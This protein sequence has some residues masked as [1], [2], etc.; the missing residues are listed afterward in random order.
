MTR[1]MLVLALLAGGLVAAPAWA[2]KVVDTSGELRVTDEVG[3]Y[4]AD[5]IAKAKEAFQ[6]ATF[7]GHVKFT[8]HTIKTIPESKRTD[9]DAVKNDKDRR[10]AFVSDWARELARKEVTKADV[11]ALVLVN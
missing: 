1:L 2:S 8:V 6:S 11:Y 7:H 3:L 4:T 10:A 5:S 9:F